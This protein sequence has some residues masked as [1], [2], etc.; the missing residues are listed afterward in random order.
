MTTLKDGTS[1]LCPKCCN[2]E[3]QVIQSVEGGDDIV[4]PESLPKLI[5]DQTE[6]PMLMASDPVT[7][8]LCSFCGSIHAWDGKKWQDTGINLKKEAEAQMG[9]MPPVKHSPDTS[10]GCAMF[11]RDEG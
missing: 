1:V 5:E 8:M 2:S 3:V 6:P 7:R 4:V 11:P 9:A 10:T